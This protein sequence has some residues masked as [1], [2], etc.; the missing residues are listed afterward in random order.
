MNK[1]N[2]PLWLDRYETIWLVHISR[3]VIGPLQNALIGQRNDLKQVF[4]R[5]EDYSQIHKLLL[6]G[7]PESRNKNCVQI[8]YE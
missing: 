1:N 3:I 5:L 6:S 4:T 8:I 2:E 7:I